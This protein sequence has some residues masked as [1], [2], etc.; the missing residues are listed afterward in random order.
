MATVLGGLLGVPHG[1]PIQ[2]ASTEI[3]LIQVAG[4]PDPS[5]RLAPPSP[6]PDIPGDD[7]GWA[8]DHD[9]P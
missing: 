3:R 7:K 2:V 6:L 8:D 5:A 1:A 9:E 4:S